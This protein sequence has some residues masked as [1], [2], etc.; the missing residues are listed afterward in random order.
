MKQGV[1]VLEILSKSPLF[2]G[3]SPDEISACLNC[4]HVQTKMYEKEELIFQQ[5]ALPQSLLVLLTGSVVVGQHGSDGSR[6]IVAAFEQPG[7]LFGEVFVFLNK[8]YEHFAQASAPT[9]VLAL[10]KDFLTHTCG[11]GC[12]SHVRMISNLLAILAEKS[13][14]LNRRVQVLSRPTLRQKLAA[15]LL[16]NANENDT[17]TL[18]MNREELADYLNAA[19]PSVSRELMR[20]QRDGLIQLRQA[21]IFINRAALQALL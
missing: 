15:L 3:L 11:H 12:P 16:Q 2:A 14:A 20:M 18:Y 13:Y 9:K 21:D 6:R 10:P 1:F 7:E 8:P 17:A 5:E 4:A 19:R